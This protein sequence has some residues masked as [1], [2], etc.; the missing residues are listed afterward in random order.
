MTAA[1]LARVVAIREALEAEMSDEPL[2]VSVPASILGQLRILLR[3]GRPDLAA[4][5]VREHMRG[6]PML[7]RCRGCEL[8]FLTR[9]RRRR[10][11]DPCRAARRRDG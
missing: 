2:T 5:L 10:Y 3:L 9:D 8:V 7:R 1:E 6:W 11:C 4:E